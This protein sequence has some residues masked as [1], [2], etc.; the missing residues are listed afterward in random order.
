MQKLPLPHGSAG[1]SRM[2]LMDPGYTSLDLC[3]HLLP[4]ELLLDSAQCTSLESGS[5]NKILH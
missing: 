2:D 4:F 3:L 1:R 5:R